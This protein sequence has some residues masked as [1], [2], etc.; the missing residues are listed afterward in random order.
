MKIRC[1]DGYDF[2]TQATTVVLVCGLFALG[3]SAL[4]SSPE[5]RFVRDPIN[6]CLVVEQVETD[7]RIYCGKACSQD[8]VINVYQCK[9]GRHYRILEA[10]E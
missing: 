1:D 8:A 2:V 6:R 5:K 9:D 4:F 7:E 3:A 10:R